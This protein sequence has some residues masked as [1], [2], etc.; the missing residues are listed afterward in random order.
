M[1]T[2]IAVR[3]IQGT[4]LKEAIHQQIILNQIKAGNIASCV[5]SLSMLKIRLA[6]ALNTLTL[7]EPLEIVSIMGTLTPKHA[8]I[9]IS[10]ANQKGEVLGG[11]LLDGSIIDTTGELIIHSYPQ[12]TFS[13][14]YDANTGF[15]ELSIS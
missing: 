3:L 8:H 2:P 11:H 15:T 12:L 5:G 10:V 7:Q 14:E 13:R 6:G 1:I 9:H 4:D